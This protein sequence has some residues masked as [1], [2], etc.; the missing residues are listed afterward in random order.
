MKKLL[1]V[2][3]VIS[4]SYSVKPLFSDIKTP[5]ETGEICG[6]VLNDENVAL[7]GCI[8][9]RDDNGTG[10]VTDDAGF[11]KMTAV[12]LG[13]YRLLVSRAGYKKLSH[14]I[15]VEADKITYLALALTPDTANS[16]QSD[17]PRKVLVNPERTGSWWIVH[18][19]DDDMPVFSL[20]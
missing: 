15:K 12:P 4:I 8:V 18:F 16:H 2:F 6:V 3:L 11:F 7:P 13:S 1:M 9:L 17:P 14:W 5:P 19:D 20:K 10:V